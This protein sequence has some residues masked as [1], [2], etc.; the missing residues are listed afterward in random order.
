MNIFV[1]LGNPGSRYELTRHNAGFMVL[2]NL[3]KVLECPE[4]T[5]NKKVFSDTCK[6]KDAIFV[7]PQTFMND[8]GRAVQS[9]LSFY[10]MDVEAKKTGGYH[11]LFVVHDDLDI[12]LGTFKIQYG[13]GP[14]GHNGLLSLY[15]NLGTQNFWHI[16]VGVDTREGDRT[17]PPQTYVL[18]KFSP[19]E[20][21]V[22]NRVKI[23]VVKELI[24]RV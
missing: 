3:S 20:M 10:K 2:D 13:I 6:V 12:P 17:L 11:N 22:F 8:S 19:E 24:Q 9:I 5:H 21:E 23:D 16:R 1:G 7:K 15:Q 18:E 4:F 14:K